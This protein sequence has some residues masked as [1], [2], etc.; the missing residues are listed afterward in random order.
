MCVVPVRVQHSDSDKE[1]KTFALL[2]TCSQGT[3]VTEDLISKL[4]V[5]GVKTS[6]NIK[7]LNGNQK[8]SSSVQGLMVSA[9]I[10]LP[11]NQIHWIKLPK[12]FT[13]KE[14]PV[15]P[16]E[17][18]T[19][20]KLKKWKHLDKVTKHLAT[21]DEVSVDLLIGANCVQALEPVDV[22]SS[23]CGG[24]YSFRTIL[25]W[26]I[27]GPIEDK[28]GSH[29][30]IS[31]N[32]VRVA[33][34]GIRENSIAKH[35]FEIPSKVDD[36]GIKEMWQRMYELDFVEPKML[37]NNV[38]TDKLEEIS[39]KDKRFLRIMNE[40]TIRVGN[41]HQTP[42]P[43]RNPAMMLPNN[44]RMVEKRA[45]HLKRHFERDPK[46]FQHYKIFMNEIISLTGTLNSQMM[47]H[48]MEGSGIYHT[49]EFTIHSNLRKSKLSSIAALS[50]E[51]G[52]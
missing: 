6:I 45:Q 24:P 48:K 38:M 35:H 18:A 9:P 26:C 1:V 39:Y 25:G 42:L 30:T 50:I 46:Y 21:D 40:Q 14:I 12:S 7:T 29:G 37:S 19:Q 36:V 32:H 17:I 8:Q 41:H 27:V 13:R 15:D 33:E 3:F 47:H 4:G 43:L 5:S 11:S 49:M 44:R 20:I 28:M 2:D 22:I 23:Q 31:C 34:A 51:E 52:Q 16:M 10:T